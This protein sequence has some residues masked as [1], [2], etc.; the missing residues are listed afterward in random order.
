MRT[1]NLIFKVCATV[2][3]LMSAWSARGQ[4][5]TQT[6]TVKPGWNAVFLHVDAS[7][8]SV[9][10]LLSGLPINEVWL[11]QPN[12]STLQF[13]TSPDEPIQSS[14][15]WLQWDRFAPS[16][17]TLDHMTG[18]AA[19]LIKVDE[20]LGNDYDWNL[21]GKPVAPFY[22]WSIDGVNLVDCQDR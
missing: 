5:Q 13:V 18:N 22:L 21:K 6:M 20:G 11:W 12:L 9:A 4:W 15:R 2:A 8:V 7:H 17:A 19:Y 14:T 10:D 16:D 3:L 1:R